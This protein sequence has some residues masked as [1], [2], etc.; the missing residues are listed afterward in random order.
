MLSAKAFGKKPAVQPNPAATVANQNHRHHQAQSPAKQ[1]LPK[2]TQALPGGPRSRIPVDFYGSPRKDGHWSPQPRHQQ[3][4]PG[5]EPFY[6]LSADAYHTEFGPVGT[7]GP[8]EKP[9]DSSFGTREST[10]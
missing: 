5:E 6:H 2:P 7:A 10:I 1:P 4:L 9:V 3:P 8:I